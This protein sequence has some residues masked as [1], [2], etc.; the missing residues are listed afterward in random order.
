[1][2]KFTTALVGLM[3]AVTLAGPASAENVL[4]W[5]SVSG[6]LTADPHAYDE[7]GTVAQLSQVY[8]GLVGL[9]SNLE[10]V[11][12]LATSW[13][14]VDPT[15]WEFELRPN[16]RFH[17]GTPFTAA[18]AAFSIARARTELPS[19]F[20]DRTES[21]ADMQVIDEHTLRIVTK[22]T[23]PQLY[24][25]LRTIRIMSQRW[26]EAHDA[27]VPVSPSAGE[28]NYASRH[29]NGTGP[30]ILK[31]FEPNGPLIMVRNADWWGLERNP[32]NIDRIEYT[33]IADSEARLAALLRGDLS[34]LI[35]PPFTALDR[36]KS[37]P[38]LK[39]A[40]VPDLF[41][42]Y[43]GLDQR[44]AELRTSDI[45][46][47]NPF[48]D[49]QV[50]QAIYQ[51]IDIEAIRETVMRGLAIPAG[52]MVSPGVNGYAPE[53]DRRLPY[54]PETAKNLLV[55]AGYTNGFSVILDCPNNRYINDEA[56]CQAIAAQLGEIGIEVTVNAQPK[57]LIFAKVDNHESDFHLL[58]WAVSGTFDSS[59]VFFNLYRAKSALNSTG[60]S[61]PR[62][63][64]TI[65]KIDR[66]M[67][68]YARD[69][70]IEEVWK[71]VLDDIVY[72]PLHH[73]II[74]WAMRDN[75]EIPVFAYNQPNFREARFKTP[76]VN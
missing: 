24:D 5:A 14:L 59:D 20:A 70:M 45:N 56:I 26:A 32:H 46:G 52:M 57:Q 47:R 72:I 65:E 1:M 6:A 41:T 33:P 49:K 67:I 55:A 15:T 2:S 16:V 29:A 51:A 18:D 34:L 60:Y 40:Q 35:D 62:I 69:A 25:N 61:N 8:E 64:E 28:E 44:S 58:G 4:R 7:G 37:T 74:V 36:I 3:A 31:E 22:F 73:Q 75:L 30:F 63:D 9:D 17:D 43:L 50:R 10:L 27:G 12:Q 19:G 68:T 23:A 66:T 38:G 54:S 48:S 71:I 11:P 53:L 13:R 39:L 76:K 42:I 21:I